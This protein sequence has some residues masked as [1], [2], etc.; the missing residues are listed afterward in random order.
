MVGSKSKT[1]TIQTNHYEVPANHYDD[2]PTIVHLGPREA[3]TTGRDQAPA[4]GNR[5]G[6]RVR[7]QQ[8]Q[9]QQLPEEN[10]AHVPTPNNRSNISSNNNNDSNNRHSNNDTQQG[11]R[12]RHNDNNNN[13]EHQRQ[14]DIDSRNRNLIIEGIIERREGDWGPID[15][16]LSYIGCRDLMRNIL[17]DPIRLGIKEF[18]KYGNSTKPRRGPRLIKLVF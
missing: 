10:T 8:Q 9:Q 6:G 13:D 7:G 11:Q 4:A 2:V 14:R 5:Q 12:D 16:I 15:D 18:I 1:Q 3:P 17:G